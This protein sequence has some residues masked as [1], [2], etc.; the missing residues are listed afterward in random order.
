MKTIVD[1]FKGL[2]D[3]FRNEPCGIS[4]K[5]VGLFKKRFVYRKFKV[6]D[7]VYYPHIVVPRNLVV[8]D[9]LPDNMYSCQDVNDGFWGKFHA[10][11]L[12]KKEG[13]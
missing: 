4:V 13:V 2:L 11:V 12:V 9:V 6:G 8:V 10:R 3:P 7:K 5:R 1:W